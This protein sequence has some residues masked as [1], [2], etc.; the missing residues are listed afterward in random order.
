MSSASEI[1]FISAA[2]VSKVLLVATTGLV[3][4]S[5]MSGG[6]KSVKGL[7]FYV[8]YIQLPC[9]LY[10]QLVDN[11]TWDLLRQC[12]AALLF[13]C[14]ALGIG[15]GCGLVAQRFVAEEARGHVI[16]GCTFQNAVSFALSMLY[17]VRGVPWLEGSAL[18][19]GIAYIFIYNIPT[20]LFLWGFGGLIVRN[21]AEELAAKSGK[22]VKPKGTFFSDVLYPLITTPPVTATLCAV[23][24]ALVYPVKW[25]VTAQPLSTVM[26]GVRVVADGCVPLQ[27]LVLGCNLMSAPPP[28]PP[29]SPSSSK[30]PID[31]NGSP[32]GPL[33]SPPV[34]LEGGGQF[35]GV[36]FQK[37]N[38][39]PKEVSS[40]TGTHSGSAR[41]LGIIVTIVRLFVIPAL[42]FLLMH[43]MILFGLIPQS[44]VFRFV[45]LI[46]SCAPSAINVSILCTVYD[47]FPR[48]Y[49]QMLVVCYVAAVLTT[50]AW[51]SLYLWAI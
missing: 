15:Y 25:L 44:K 43:V 7:S 12:W 5:Q 6:A 16:L 21:A 41:R 34:A 37:E 4:A 24:T 39:S 38:G 50:T 35:P 48:R 22:K 32:N 31:A 13:S 14:A 49:T 26:S 45:M 3:L 51:M 23:F 46:E 47:Y 42:V 11:L 33:I 20:N 17:S 2:T 10:S 8:G 30:S 27:L 28:A 29:A 36:A 19:E 9:L 18:S 1:F 40:P